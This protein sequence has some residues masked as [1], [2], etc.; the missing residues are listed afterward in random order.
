MI[1]H[2]IFY[3]TDQEISTFFYSHVLQLAPTL[4]VPG[5][6]E[7]QLSE[8]CV[9]GIMPESGIKRLIGSS[10][11]DPASAQGVPRAELYLVVVNANDYYKR[12][13]AAGGTALSD[14]CER[15]WGQS[16]GYCLDKDGHVLA[17]AH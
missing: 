10:L 11:P 16:V 2:L 13:L 3:V 4:N 9:L 5:M 7:F 8:T 17:F 14:V 6:T 1:A 12:A 15:D